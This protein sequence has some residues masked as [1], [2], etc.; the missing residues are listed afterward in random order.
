ME[1]LK[2]TKKI[3]MLQ[4]IKRRDEE[5]KKDWVRHQL[6]YENNKNFIKKEINIE[7]D[8]K[9]DLL[10]KIPDHIKSKCV[11]LVLDQLQKAYVSVLQKMV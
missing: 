4:D 9:A 6:Y 11:A 7:I 10:E 3:K 1:K 8:I 5:I 2:K